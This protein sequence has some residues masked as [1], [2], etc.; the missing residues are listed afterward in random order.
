MDE[1]RINI[2]IDSSD[3]GWTFMTEAA[4]GITE[5]QADSGAFVEVNREGDELIGRQIAGAKFHSL[6]ELMVWFIS[7]QD[8][9]WRWLAGEMLAPPHE[10]TRITRGMYG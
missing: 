1:R 5:E 4:V 10:L 2:F 9:I 7:S 8:E 3:G 6:P